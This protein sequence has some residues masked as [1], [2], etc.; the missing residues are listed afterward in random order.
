MLI[1]CWTIIIIV[2]AM[3]FIFLRSGRRNYFFNILP[4][5]FIPAVHLIVYYANKAPVELP[6]AESGL[7]FVGADILTLLVSCLCLGFFAHNFQTRRNRLLYLCVCGV[8]SFALT[9]LL[10]LGNLP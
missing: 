1:E 9:F 10:I 5:T 8:F 7:L 6:G 2:T 3:A 4:L